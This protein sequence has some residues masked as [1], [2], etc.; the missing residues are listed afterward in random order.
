MKENTKLFSERVKIY[1]HLPKA[2]FHKVGKIIYAMI[3][4]SCGWHTDNCENFEIAGWQ[5]DLH[6]KRFENRIKMK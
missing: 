2:I 1:N 4:C 5:F 3:L 6:E